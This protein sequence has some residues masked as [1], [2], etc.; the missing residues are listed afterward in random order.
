MS[1]DLVTPGSPGMQPDE[2]VAARFLSRYREPTRTGYAVSLRLWFQW[3]HSKGIQPMQVERAHIELWARELEEV[4]GNKPATICGKLNAVCGMYKYAQR[5]RFLEHNP[6]EWVERPKVPRFSSTEGLTRTEM[7]AVLD[8]A[9]ISGPRDHALLCILGLNGLR[10][11]EAIALNVEDLGMKQSYRTIKF[12]RE[13]K[14][15]MVDEMPLSPR[16]TRAIEQA[17]YPRT[18]GP[19][20]LMRGLNGGE[21]QRMDRRAADRVV[22]RLCKEA[23]ITKRITPHSFRHSFVTL[24]L[25]AGVS[26][27]DVQNSVGHADPRMVAYYDRNRNSLPRHATH[28]L[29]AFVEGS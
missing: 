10:V 27:R 2:I 17:I 9:Q 4:N 11:G 3:C 5:D 26:V 24:S 12:T 29:S 23:G 14:D 8:R 18:S 7:L 15:G 28:Y 13:K 6:A 1:T 21:P 22:K 16:T 19:V 20:F 25:D